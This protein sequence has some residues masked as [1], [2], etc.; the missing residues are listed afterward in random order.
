MWTGKN[1]YQE[2]GHGLMEITIKIE[3]EGKYAFE[4]SNS[5]GIG[6]NPTESNDTWLRFPNAAKFYGEKT[7]E[8]KV[9]RVYPKESG[10]TPEPEG[11]GADGWFK[12]YSS[13][14]ID[15]SWNCF[16]NDND[17]YPIFVE[18]DEPGEYTLQISGRSQGHSIDVIRL[19]HSSVNKENIKK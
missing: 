10:K 11:A 7:E 3:Q 8:G 15:W 13:Q 19:Y 16:V 17:G 2:P 9:L 4:W 14:T 1:Y 12:V 6:D 18:F 5:V